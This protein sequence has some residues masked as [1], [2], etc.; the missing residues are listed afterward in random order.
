[1]TGWGWSYEFSD[2]EGTKRAQVNATGLEN[3][4]QSDP[5]SDYLTALTSNGDATEHH[6][7]QKERDTESGNDKFGARY[8][9]SLMGRFMSPDWSAKVEPVPYAKLTNPQSLNLFAFVGNNPLSHVDVDG[10]APLSWG[11]F[12][13]CSLRGDCGVNA[14][15]MGFRPS[16]VLDNSA[17]PTGRGQ[18]SAAEEAQQS[19]EV[20]ERNLDRSWPLNHYN[21]TYLSIPD[22]NGT[23]HTYGVLG[24]RNQDGK[25]T[26]KEQQVREDDNRNGALPSTKHFHTYSVSVSAA[27]LSAIRQAANHWATPGNT[28]PSCGSNY[29][30]SGLTGSSG[31]PYNSNTWVY[32]ML[33][34]NPAGRIE[35][36]TIANP[37]PGWNVN[38]AGNNYYPG[39]P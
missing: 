33:I 17:A 7:T 15:G 4:W 28:C 8:Y 39:V 10:H 5:Y 26:G 32:N 24:K 38:D 2:W 6:L 16:P 30:A 22:E 27:Q 9:T 19:I 1:L 23:M 37:A 21:H 14:P 25:G 3:Y 13:D 36:P 34:Q 18:N 12:E 11:G 29:N 20:G 35:P 31:G